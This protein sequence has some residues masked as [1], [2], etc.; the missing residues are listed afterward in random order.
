MCH[1]LTFKKCLILD[2]GILELP[3]QRKIFS[4]SMLNDIMRNESPSLDYFMKLLHHGPDVVN[5]F[6]DILMEPKQNDIVIC[7]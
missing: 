1:L 7:F 3:L 6:I 5:Q 2:G 4:Q